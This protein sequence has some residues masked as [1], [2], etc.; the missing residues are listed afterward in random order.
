MH[1][2]PLADSI[3]GFAQRLPVQDVPLVARDL[4]LV[5]SR[6]LAPGQSH[7]QEE[8][9]RLT[10]V[11][12]TKAAAHAALLLSVGGYPDGGVHGGHL[13]VVWNQGVDGYALSMHFADRS[14]R[15]RR[16]QEAI[17]LSAADR[18]G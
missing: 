7:G 16:R 4:G 3:R 15:E 9:A 18:L 10:L 2:I 17:L 1:N 12:R 5:G 11:R 14:T 6:P 13:A 8:P